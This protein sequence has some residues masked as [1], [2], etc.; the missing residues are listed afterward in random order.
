MSRSYEE[1]A[2]GQ[3]SGTSFA[4]RDKNVSPS[5]PQQQVAAPH[6]RRGSQ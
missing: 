3:I 5:N 4:G 1:V 2:E 6:Q